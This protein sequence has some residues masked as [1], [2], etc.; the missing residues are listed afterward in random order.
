M[1]TITFYSYKGGVGRSLALSNVANRLSEFGKKVC[2]LDFDLE[3]PGLHLKFEK[4]IGNKGVQKGLVDYIHDFCVSKKVPN[5]LSDFVTKI[6]FDKGRHKDISLIA[7]GNTL[8][9]DYWK[10]LSA[11]NWNDMF[12]SKN[13][14][15]VEFF[16]NLKAQIEL[17]IKPDFLLID[18]RT[19]I[20][21]ISGVTMSI[22]A[23]EVVLLA[24][25]NKENLQ[26]ITQVIKTLSNPSNSIHNAS[27]KINLVLSRIPYFAKSRFKA[28]ETVVKSAA[29][30]I[31]N[32]GLK[33]CDIDKFT[34]DKLL[35]I[36]SDPDLEIEEKLKIS[37]GFENKDDNSV[38]PIG[39]DY[40]NLFEEITH[41]IIT[42][43]DKKA[44]DKFIK[45]ESLIEKS[46]GNP[47]IPSRIRGL[48]SAIKLS[49]KSSTAHKHLGIT[50]Y[51]TKS[52]E[53]ALESFR[54]AL[55]I[56]PSLEEDI[57]FHKALC[58]TGLGKIDQALNIYKG[59]LEKDEQ[60]KSAYTPYVQMNISQLYQ[61]KNEPEN[62]LVYAEKAIELDPENE[63]VWI[64]YGNTLRLLGKYDE[65]LDS[66]YKALEIDPQ[67]T[68]ATGTLAEIYAALGNLREFYKNLE[69]SLSF[70][71][72]NED[73]QRILL[74]EKV[75]KQ[76]FKDQKFLSIIEKYKMD[77]DWSA[78]TN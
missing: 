26:G 10:Q 42:D 6:N 60:N 21:D 77:I 18:S 7:A 63:N 11:I 52:Y 9:A 58:Y 14:V 13:S 36:H 41:G 20:T 12:Y 54:K 75:Y 28:K 33:E 8:S 61:R 47:D 65:S 30:R 48:E 71:M 2:L 40:L 1:R 55:E 45:V 73:F 39:L 5:K 29:L 35:I 68:Y 3:A 25:N 70:G 78:M 49:P 32:E 53:K 69:L 62:A 44:F 64:T 50:F 72:S 4:Q 38:I 23:D 16:L 15:G 43:R 51:E 22:L 27:P 76:F 67:N 56:D 46:I 37:Y 74:E 34:V 24:A 19:G 66:I 59:A 17:Q 57:F 31:I